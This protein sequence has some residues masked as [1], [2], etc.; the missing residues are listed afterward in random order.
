MKYWAIF[1]RAQESDIYWNW[2]FINKSKVKQ[3]LSKLYAAREMLVI[4]FHANTES[5]WKQ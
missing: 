5:N 4:S 2:N 1:Q 3:S